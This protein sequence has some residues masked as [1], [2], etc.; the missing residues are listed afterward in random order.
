MNKVVDV[1][2]DNSPLSPNPQDQL[3]DGESA[4]G[5]D[6]LLKDPN[7][8]RV[9]QDRAQLKMRETRILGVSPAKKHEIPKD[10]LN[11]YISEAK[12]ASKILG[13]KNQYGPQF[14]YKLDLGEK[15][16]YDTELEVTST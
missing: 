7:R 15:E 11:R 8:E 10:I 9:M 12:E 3:E 5:H 2:V 1:V 14:E 16:V 4:A 13:L 6:P